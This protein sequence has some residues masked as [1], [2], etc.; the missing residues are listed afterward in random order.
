MKQFSGCPKKFRFLRAK[1]APRIPSNRWKRIGSLVHEALRIEGRGRANRWDG[2]KK[3]EEPVTPSDLERHLAKAAQSTDESCL[4]S[5]IEEAREILQECASN[6]DFTGVTHVE[7]PFEFLVAP[8]GP[9]FIG[10]FDFVRLVGDP[11]APS[12]VFIKDYKT[13]YNVMSSSDHED[14]DQANGYAVAAKAIWPTAKKITVQF[15][16][17]EIEHAVQTIEWTPSL[18]QAFRARAEDVYK[19][20]RDGKDEKGTPNRWECNECPLVETCQEYKALV[21]ADPV[22]GVKD[23]SLPSD[24]LLV[25]REEHA[26]LAEAE[27]ERKKACDAVIKTRLDKKGVLAAGG[28]RAKLVSKQVGFEEPGLA[29]VAELLKDMASL[30]IAMTTAKLATVDKK[31]LKAL[32]AELPADKRDAIN[33]ELK[34][35]RRLKSGSPYVEV[36]T[37]KGS[38]F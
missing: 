28:L 29:E 30:D 20:I 15:Q 14:D 4:V 12:E 23:E 36:R 9:K 24:K 13:G 1:D 10:V 18:D 32:L 11:K 5:E 38:G 3:P 34:N 35:R 26:A 7:L 33:A 22:I 2:Y 16:W 19:R 25:K 21:A 6:I 37:I 8:P 27:A 31:A 17:V